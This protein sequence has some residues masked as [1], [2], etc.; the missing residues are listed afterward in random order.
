MTNAQMSVKPFES[1]KLK[2]SLFS[3]ASTDIHWQ[4][5]AITLARHASPI[6]LEGGFPQTHFQQRIEMG[7]WVE[8]ILS[9][10][11]LRLVPRLQPSLGMLP[12][13]LFTEA[14]GGS[15]FT[16]IFST[17]VPVI[18][19]ME[20]CPV[21]LLMDHAKLKT[22]DIYTYKFYCDAYFHWNRG[23]WYFRAMEPH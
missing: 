18:N 6:E 9:C 14:T 22:F 20:T 16:I 3:V 13:H 1:V 21:R 23:P 11:R 17:P 4:D 7:V 8:G 10:F 5:K 19:L 15:H 12:L 2:N